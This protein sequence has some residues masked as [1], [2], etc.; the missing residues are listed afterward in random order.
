MNKTDLVNVM[1]KDAGISKAAAQAALD[2]LTLNITNTLKKGEKVA[3]VGW[4]TWLASQRAE[5]TG[6][7]PNTGKPIKIEAKK[8]VKFRAGTKF[9]K[10]L[11][12]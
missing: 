11:N 8:V 4:G 6:I 9:I 10:D 3:L 7:H 5:R 2:S 1:A 12:S